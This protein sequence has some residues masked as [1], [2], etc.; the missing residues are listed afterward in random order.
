MLLDLSNE[1]FRSWIVSWLQ[2]LEDETLVDIEALFTVSPG[3]FPSTLLE[4][5]R[6]E[7]TRRGLVAIVPSWTDLDP[8]APHPPDIRLPVGHA[9]DADW[10]FTPACARQLAQELTGA[11]P[12]GSTVAHLGAPTTFLYGLLDAG[13]HQHVLLDRNEAMLETLAA[14][15]HAP[16][17]LLRHDL[18]RCDLPPDMHASAAIADPPWY[19]E[20]TIVFLIA[21]AGLCVPDALILL[22][23][24]SVGTRPGVEAERRRLLDELPGLGLTL[25]DVRSGALHYQTP[26]FEATALRTA[27]KEISRLRSWR[28]GDLLVLRRTSAIRPRLVV[29]PRAEEWHEVRFGPVRI[30]VRNRATG[31]RDLDSMV[32][33]DVLPNV[34]RRDRIR[35]HIGLWTSGNRVYRIAH[36]KSICTVIELCHTDLM[37]EAFTIGSVR[38]HVAALGLP[39]DIAD[40]LHQLLSRELREHQESLG[41]F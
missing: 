41:G 21:A 36:P 1:D 17:K 19:L 9:L 34:S 26:H 10:R 38:R 30:K 33:G 40:K 29:S 11:L 35:A 6:C 28:R 2:S 16:H 7:L 32:T 8:P 4:L 14:V 31:P 39:P 15:A 25:E 20:D 27:M 5:W 24:P 23:Q 3:I 12:D 22:C 18:A 13:V 37:H